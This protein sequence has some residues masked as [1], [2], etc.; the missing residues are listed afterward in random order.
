[1]LVWM[2]LE[3]LYFFWKGLKAQGPD[4]VQPLFFQRQWGNIQHTLLSF[5]RN[6]FLSGQISEVILKAHVVLIPKVECPE[7]ILDF[8]PITLLNTAYKLISKVLVARLRPILQRVVG[9]FQNSFLAGRSTA[10]NI[11]VTQEE[12]HSLMNRKGRQ[13]GILSLIFIK[14]MILLVGNSF[15]KPCCCLISLSI[16]LISSCFLLVTWLLLLFGMVKNSLNSLLAG[17]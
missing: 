3:K 9:P 5:V 13:G 17:V 4:G 11:L 7:S 6:A 12:I 2:R 14:R 16:W 8:R 1:M 10:D 15:E